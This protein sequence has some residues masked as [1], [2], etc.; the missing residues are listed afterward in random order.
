M[1]DSE[2]TEQEKLA[3]L[4]GKEDNVEEID[5]ADMLTQGLLKRLGG[6]NPKYLQV[7]QEEIDASG[8]V[9]DYTPISSLSASKRTAN[10]PKKDEKLI[11]ALKSI[12]A[13]QIDIF[14]RIGLNSG[15][16]EIL[17]AIINRTAACI[18]YLGEPIEEF[19]PL[20]HLSGLGSPDMIKNANKVIDTTI[21]C[22]RL[23]KIVE[24]NI[25]EDGSS[26]DIVFSGRSGN[27]EYK[28]YGQVSADSWEGSE[29]IDYIYTR[30]SGK[31][32]VKTFE[33][34]KWVDKS[35]TTLYD[36]RWELEEIDL[37]EKNNPSIEKNEIVDNEKNI[38]N[39]KEVKVAILN[40]KDKGNDDGDEDDD[41]EEIGDD[42]VV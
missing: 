25:S 4:M 13:A 36:I 23:G 2:L 14:E 9:S 3:R 40:N 22:Y 38:T 17:T 27:I 37:S 42:I 26:I 41:E 6:A 19:K 28:V 20:S 15:V 16:E 39:K 1:R 32:S 34:G 30:G 11:L 5:S 35:D 29:A 31:M 18:K 10:E 33:S 24:T 7:I 12:Y 8:A 21:Q